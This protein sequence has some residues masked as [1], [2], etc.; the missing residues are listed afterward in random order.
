MTRSVA[1]LCIRLLILLAA[2]LLG[3]SALADSLD[4]LPLEIRPFRVQLLIAFDDPLLSQHA[5]LEI[6]HGARLTANRCIGSQWQLEVDEAAWLQPVSARGLKRLN[7]AEICRRTQKQASEHDVWLVA[8][9]QSNGSGWRI[10][11]RAWQPAIELESEPAGADVYD[12]LEVP[13]V[14]LQLG[15]AAFRSVGIVDEVE[16]NQVRVLLQAGALSVPDESFSLIRGARFFVPILASRKR[17]RTIDRLQPIPWTVLSTSTPTDQTAS[18]SKD[19]RVTCELHSGLRSPIGGKQRGRVETLAVAVKPVFPSTRLDL[20][21][22]SR[23]SL[24]LVAHRIELRMSAEIP[25][26]DAAEERDKRRLAVLLTDRRGQ[27]MIAAESDPSLVWLFAYSG[28]QLLARVPIVPGSSTNLRLEVPDD[29]ARLEAESNLSILRGELIEAVAARNTAIA[30]VRS[31]VKKNDAKLA[32][33]AVEEL[34]KQPD[35]QFFLNKV[36][37]IRVPSV[38]AAKARKD[39][40]GEVRIVRMCDEVA[41]LIKQYLNDD[42]RQLVIEEI[43][44]LYTDDDEPAEPV[45]PANPAEPAKS[46]TKD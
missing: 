40:A 34:K 41:D 35:A 43:R 23:P 24:P 26:K 37:A 19:G 28:G 14:M 13:L 25:A 31:A 33:L 21:T 5:R 10:D 2:L 36:N 45:E 12:R 7:I 22:Q 29:S 30:R 20:A 38:K 3:R 4:E 44:E 16:G 8:A 15:H 18:E 6:L 17:D 11:V 27:A 1:R 42:K 39:R 9:I 32:G 46:A